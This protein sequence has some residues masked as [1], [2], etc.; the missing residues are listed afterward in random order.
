MSILNFPTNVPKPSANMPRKRAARVNS[1]T[2]GDGYSQRSGDGLNS[3]ADSISL[4]WP[5]LPKEKAAIID[6][7]LTERAGEK[8][9]YWTAPRAAT[10]QKWTCAT[11]ERTP[12]KNK[13]GWDR[14]TATFTEAFDL[15]D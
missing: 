9:F 10:P 2:Y 13:T 1:L 14:I 5:S 4:A 6:D 3:V 8:A 15:D 11:W 7:F 12:I